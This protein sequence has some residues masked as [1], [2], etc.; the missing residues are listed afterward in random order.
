MK[1]SNFV[2]ARKGSERVVLSKISSPRF[3]NYPIQST[4]K[5][6]TPSS[7][8]FETS[9]LSVPRI[10]QKFSS[11]RLPVYMTSGDYDVISVVTRQEL[12]IYYTSC[13]SFNNAGRSEP[14]R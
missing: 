9:I 10:K 7:H 2:N 12:T 13:S 3:K 14:K 8:C 1:T 6:F 11:V 4:L 5:N